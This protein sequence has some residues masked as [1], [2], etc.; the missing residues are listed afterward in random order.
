M[1]NF[2]QPDNN[3]GLILFEKSG[4]YFDTDVTPLRLTALLPDAQ[5]I[6]ILMDPAE[7][8]YSWYQHQRYHGNTAAKKHT[9]QEIL[10]A[11]ISDPVAWQLKSRCLSPGL[12]SQHLDKWLGYLTENQIIFVDGAKL[13]TE[14][15]QVMTNLQ[16]SLKLENIIDYTSLLR[17]DEKKGF[18]CQ[19]YPS[20]KCLGASKGRQYPPM[21][22]KSREL[23]D[24]YYAMPNV[25][26][27]MKLVKFG[28]EIPKWLLP[29]SLK[30]NL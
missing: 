21:D 18:F 29:T 9:F 8:A 5:I 4:N 12:Y 15:V 28:A 17:F 26:L 2:P 1:D 16:H 7:R 20:H 25:H 27:R 30:R 14:P 23:L 22:S 19:A 3:S 24:E 13:R 6:V 11:N 10:Q